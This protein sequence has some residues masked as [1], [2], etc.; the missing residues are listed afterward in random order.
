MTATFDDYTARL[1]A[2]E[3]LTAAQ[4]L[5]LVNA[6]DVLQIGMLADTVR[7]RLHG[8]RT[9]FLRVQQIPLDGPMVLQPAARELRLLGTPASMNAALTAVAGG[10]S[11]AGARTLS[12]FSWPDLEQIA[13]SDIA[14]ALD[15]LR[16]AGLDAFSELPLDAMADP[17]AALDQLAGAGFRV[18]RLTVRSAPASERLDL[19]IAAGALCARFPIVK[20]INPLPL[21]LHPFRPT[22]GYDDVKMVAAARLAVLG[23]S[24]QVDWLRYGPKLAQVALGFG[25]DDIDGVS[26]SDEAPEG[27]RRAPLEEIRRNIE[28]AGC[29]AVERDGG[30]DILQ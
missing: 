17:A 3:R 26:A 23:I 24:V 19:L 11:A 16:G 25:A 28:A 5:E 1:N 15:Q 30:F 12:A 9:T 22:T 18:A 21:T 27:R 14:G 13:G 7:R 8:I 2:G 4:I 10:R 20:A 29:E 6:P